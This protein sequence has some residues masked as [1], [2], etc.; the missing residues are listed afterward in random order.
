[1]DEMDEFCDKVY[2]NKAVEEEGEEK[3]GEGEERKGRRRCTE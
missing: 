3:G 2:L 1:M